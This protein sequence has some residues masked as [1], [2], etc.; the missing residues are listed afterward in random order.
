MISEMTLHHIGYAVH[1]ISSTAQHYISAGWS[2][3][4][5][6]YDPFQKCNI[7]FLEKTNSFYIELVEQRKTT[8]EPPNDITKKENG[9][10]SNFLRNGVSPYHLCY[11]VP[12]INLAIIELRKQH[13]LLLFNP[14]PAAAIDNRVICY[15]MHPEV[16]LIELLQKK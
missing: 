6:V 10:L 2:L 1:N 5:I 8:T 12:D 3:S 9:L 7:A 4:S 15:M 11:E 13:Y 16:G 14:V